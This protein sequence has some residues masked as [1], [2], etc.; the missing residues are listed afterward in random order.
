MIRGALLSSIIHS[1]LAYEAVRD[2]LER[3][4]VAVVKN[5]ASAQVTERPSRWISE[6]L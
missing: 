3:D 5:F 6:L 4:G 1:S 2:A